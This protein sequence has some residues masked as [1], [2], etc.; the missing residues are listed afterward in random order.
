M[1]V[2]KIE[3]MKLINHFDKMNI[4]NRG[5]YFQINIIIEIVHLAKWLH[6]FNKI[7]KADKQSTCLPFYIWV[8]VFV[9]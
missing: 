4:G 7:S 8:F 1:E 9:F 5:V 2:E 3:K 6:I